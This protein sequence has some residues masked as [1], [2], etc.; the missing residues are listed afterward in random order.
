MTHYRPGSKLPQSYEEEYG[1]DDDLDDDDVDGYDCL[2]DYDEDLEY[3]EG[4]EK[5]ESY[6][7]SQHCCDDSGNSK[8]SS[9]TADLR[10]HRSISEGCPRVVEPS[11]DNRFRHTFSRFSVFHGERQIFLL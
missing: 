9:R 2:S 6:G 1:E 11:D 5:R 3:T 8:S 4:S 7:R 10:R